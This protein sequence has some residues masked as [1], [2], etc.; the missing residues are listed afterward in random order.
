MG[1]LKPDLRA[2]SGVL[3]GAGGAVIAVSLGDLT[4][5]RTPFTV[6]L[7]LIVAFV[8]LGLGATAALYTYAAAAVTM[9]VLTTAPGHGGPMSVAETVRVGAFIVGAPF[10]VLLVLRLERERQAAL[11]ARDASASATRRAEEVRELADRTRRDLDETLRRAERERARLEEVAEAIPEPLVVYDAAG[12]GTYGNRAALQLFG[13]SFFDRP[14]A[15]WAKT[16]EPRD[17]GGTPLP[18][19]AWPQLAAQDA[20]IHRR[21]VVRLPMSG[22]DL[23]V[24]VE[25]TPIPGGG[26]VLLLRDVGKEEEEHRRLSH[27]ASFVAHELR[28]PLAV[29]KARIE[30]ARRDPEL[31]AKAGVHS[32]RALESV[33]AAIGILE[34]L[35]LYSRAESGRVEARRDVFEL[36]P[37]LRAALERLRS[38]GTERE[39]LISVDGQRPRVVGDRHLSEQAITNLL[40][41]ADRYSSPGAPISVEV[42]DENPVTLRVSDTGPGIADD[43]AERLFGERVTA[44][45]GLGLGLYLVN[46]TMI[47]Q[48]GSVQ[49]EQRRPQ[50]VFALRWER[51]ARARRP[52]DALVDDALRD[53]GERQPPAAGPPSRT[54]S[55]EP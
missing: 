4:A 22:R 41:N 25:G 21:L 51:A 7:V 47:A 16:V 45:R 54:T 14:L 39:V 36:L 26:C 43:I 12:R 40:T 50:A 17:E 11:A 46:A 53:Q 8:G 55:T 10:V 28:N 38:R 42:T 5:E 2:L 15:G 9:F 1:L 3:I 37:A 30:L 32:L 6:L 35:E 29:A 44:G 24:D 13:R 18:R 33:D 31:S 20:P 49:L 23:L 48:G 27:F 34:R 19:E 52:A